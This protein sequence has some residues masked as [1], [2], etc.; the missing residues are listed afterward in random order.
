M[1][2]RSRQSEREADNE[3]DNGRFMHGEGRRGGRTEE[4]EG[5]GER[6]VRQGREG[7][8]IIGNVDHW[9]AELV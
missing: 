1:R 3:A 4:L 2:K 8:L 6:R 7:D 5:H 9:A